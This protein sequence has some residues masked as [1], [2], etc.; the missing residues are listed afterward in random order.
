MF[1]QQTFTLFLL[2]SLITNLTAQIYERDYRDS[3]Q[4]ILGGT[5]EYRV[6]SGRVDLLTDQ[7]A[8]EVEFA[9]NW[10]SAIGQ[11][12]WYGLQTNKMPAII[13]VKKKATDYKY[14]IQLGSALDYAKLNI[15]T[16]VWPDDF[17]QQK[18][19]PYGNSSSAETKI[20]WITNSSKKRHNSSCSYYENS[21][22]RHCESTDG[23]ACMRCGG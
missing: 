9:N 11:A 18:P 7:Y 16:W 22:G 17:S 20:F 4:A 8:I 12:L 15:K 21:N 19:K 5:V 13:L 2:I 14:V 6:E 10:K 23:T 1:K 3:I